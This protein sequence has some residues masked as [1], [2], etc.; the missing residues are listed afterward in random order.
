MQNFNQNRPHFARNNQ[1]R[2]NNHVQHNQNSVINPIQANQQGA[3]LQEVT[4]FATYVKFQKLTPKDLTIKDAIEIITVADRLQIARLDAL[5]SWY[6]NKGSVV[7]SAHF[8]LNVLINHNLLL[9]NKVKI[10]HYDAE[11]P[12]CLVCLTDRE[13]LSAQ[14]WHKETTKTPIWKNNPTYALEELALVRFLR[15]LFPALMMGVISPVEVPPSFISKLGVLSVVLGKGIYQKAKSFISSCFTSNNVK[16]VKNVKEEKLK[17]TD[18][19]VENDVNDKNDDEDLF[20]DL[21]DLEIRNLQKVKPI[22]QFNR[23]N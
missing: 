19:L 1:Q 7:V 21:D 4:A 16:S 3:Y 23:L 12:F 10:S 2:P 9:A 13:Q 22:T 14:A 20:L 11:E 18:K 8:I 5:K 6:V 15:N 17:N